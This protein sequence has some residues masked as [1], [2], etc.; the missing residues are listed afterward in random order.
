MDLKRWE[1]ERSRLQEQLGNCQQHL[2]IVQLQIDNLRNEELYKQVQNCP[3][4]PTDHPASGTDSPA[5]GFAG[6]PAGPSKQ[7]RQLL[8]ERLQTAR[9]A[10]NN[11][12]W[13]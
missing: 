6:Q 10:K 4:Q 5:A 12:S 11:W 3:P 1:K 8:E 9:Q 7:G 13:N 2:R